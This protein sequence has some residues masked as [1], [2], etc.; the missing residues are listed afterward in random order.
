MQRSDGPADS[1]R[2]STAGH[3]D[4]VSDS[5]SASRSNS[6]RESMI[7]VPCSPIEPETRIASPGRI[8]SA[9]S[10]ARGSRAPTPVVQ[11][12]IESA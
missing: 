8:E 12:Y 5:I 10:A 6:P 4:R 1:S 2:A 3:S 7:A 9:A 11:M